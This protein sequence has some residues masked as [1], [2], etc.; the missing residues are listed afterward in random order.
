MR[1]GTTGTDTDVDIEVAA[2]GTGSI[3]LMSQGANV[4]E[5]FGNTTPVNYLAT[6]A[7]SAGGAP[8]FEVLGAGTNVNLGLVPKGT[9]AV[10]TNAAIGVGT[11]A[12]TAGYALH[13]AKNPTG[14]TTTV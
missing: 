2:Q 7:A 5:A 4:F 9:G 6:R 1:L 10:V 8:Q 3:R 11:T 14:A 12:P 13:I